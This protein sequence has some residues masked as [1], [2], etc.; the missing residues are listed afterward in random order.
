MTGQLHVGVALD[1]YG[2]HPQAWRAT[3]VS[4]PGTP[5]VLSL[6]LIHI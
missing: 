1:G 6:S 3:L 5:S 2:W 4:D